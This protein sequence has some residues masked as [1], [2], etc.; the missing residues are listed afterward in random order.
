MFFL[1]PTVGTYC[2]LTF[3]GISKGNVPGKSYV[4]CSG[5]PLKI[6]TP[7]VWLAGRFYLMHLRKLR[8]VPGRFS[9]PQTW[10][11]ERKVVSLLCLILTSIYKFGIFIIIN[12]FIALAVFTDYSKIRNLFVVNNNKFSIVKPIVF[13]AVCNI[14]PG[15]KQSQVQCSFDD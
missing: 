10:R 12:Q 6:Q 9:E 14:G 8:V 11:K 13:H 3:S 4:H 2:L 7:H 5:F 15:L 1:V